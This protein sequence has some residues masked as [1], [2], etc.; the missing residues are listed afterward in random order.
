MS[1]A[2]EA[3]SRE[4]GDV[5]LVP[6][7]DRVPVQGP[8]DV[9]FVLDFLTAR[10]VPGAEHIIGGTY[11]RTLLLPSGPSMFTATPSPTHIAVQGWIRNDRD[12]EPLL[13]AVRY[14]FDTDVDGS[15]VDAAL[16]ANGAF[17]A[18]LR[19]HSGIRVPRAVDV[20]ELLVRAVVGQ[21]ITVKQATS[22]LTAMVADQ[23]ELPLPGPV[24]RL[25]PTVA[26]VAARQWRHYRGPDARRTTLR[27]LHEAVTRTPDILRRDL[28]AA[29]YQ[30]ELLRIRGIGPWT[31]AYVAMRAADTSD[32]LLPGD[33]GVR[34]GARALGIADVAAEATA[35]APYRSHLTMLL[36]ATAAD[37][38]H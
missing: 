23:P 35:A 14:T 15:A 3:S 1:P 12:V 29:L 21:Q 7:T 27:S 4:L 30:R 37:A 8:Y 32:V 26:D 16:C 18:P 34:A 6:F 11:S 33:A 17:A 19:R 13:Q 25:F 5:A 36:W 10:A 20:E 24:K 9:R 2:T 28:E 31:A 38:A 22:M